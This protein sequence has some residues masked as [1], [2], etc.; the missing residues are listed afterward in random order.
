MKFL[1]EEILS[2]LFPF[3]LGQLDSVD[4]VA[5]PSQELSPIEGACG[6]ATEKKFK[7][8]IDRHWN[9]PTLYR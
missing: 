9:D 7:D 1:I 3:R 4:R 2:T 8:A 6:Q 5:P